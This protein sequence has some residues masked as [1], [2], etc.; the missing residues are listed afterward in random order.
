MDLLNIEY[1]SIEPRMSRDFLVKFKNID[2]CQKFE[3]MLLKI[4]NI[5]RDTFFF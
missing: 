1:D 5:N 3:K 2:H 4:N